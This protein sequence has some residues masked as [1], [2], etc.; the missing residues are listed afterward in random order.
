[1]NKYLRAER[2]EHANN[3]EKLQIIPVNSSKNNDINSVK[4][5]NFILPVYRSFPCPCVL[6]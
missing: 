5:I 6:S 3:T 2:V 4:F 1:M